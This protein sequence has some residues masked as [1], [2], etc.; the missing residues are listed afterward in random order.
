MASKAAPGFPEPR[1]VAVL[2]SHRWGRAQPGLVLCLGLQP[3]DHVCFAGKD[4]ARGR[5]CF[6]V[7]CLPGVG[8]RRRAVRSSAPAQR[9][10]PHTDWPRARPPARTHTAPQ[11]KRR[12][13]IGSTGK[14]GGTPKTRRCANQLTDRIPQQTPQ[15]PHTSRHDPPD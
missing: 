3:P 5:G 13:Q 11:K 15:P 14:R 9:A 6:R 7:H 12:S 10:E 8:L 1:L 2:L 4:T